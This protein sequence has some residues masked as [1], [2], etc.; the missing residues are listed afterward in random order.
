M[1]NKLLR[2]ARFRYT[3]ISA[4]IFAIGAVLVSALLYFGV[5]E[6]LERQIRGQVDSEARQLMGDYRD[7]GINE[8]IH[9]IRERLE[10]ASDSRMLYA[11][12]N[13]EGEQVFDAIELTVADGWSVQKRA[14]APNLIVLTTSLADGYR[15]AVASDMRSIEELAVAFRQTIAFAVFGIG[16]VSIAAGFFVSRRFLARIE[17]FRRSAESV[18]AG[19]LATRMPVEGADDDFDALAQ[20]INRMLDHI[21]QLMN[22]V[23]YVSAGIAHDLRTPLGAL[24]RRLEA[25]ETM[26]SADDMREAAREAAQMLEETLGTFSALLKISELDAGKTAIEQKPVDLGGLIHALAEAFAPVAEDRGQRLDVSIAE[27]AWVN[28]DRRLLSQLFSNL[29]ENAIRHN[30]AGTEIRLSL[31][32]EGGDCTAIIA[33][34]GAGVAPELREDLLK[35]FVRLDESRMTPGSGLGLSL[36]ASI[37]RR[38]HAALILEDNEP[39]LRVRVHFTAS[40]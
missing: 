33:D 2:T 31:E 40:G 11:V 30:G 38:H 1:M 27:E 25:M 17:G 26:E 21:E 16:A 22:D 7:E 28:G 23:R 36:A 29:I 35:P 3:A 8:L 14:G 13:A 34:T 6:S 32:S 9:D 37:A 10:R 18:G 24:K 5:R 19:S 39:G 15:F 4:L 12:V 20:I